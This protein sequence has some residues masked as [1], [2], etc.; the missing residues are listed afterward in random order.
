MP[1]NDPGNAATA[2]EQC[3]GVHAHRE[4]TTNETLHDRY[5][6]DHHKRDRRRRVTS[7]VACIALTLALMSG[8]IVSL[9]LAS[10]V[11]AVLASVSWLSVL[12][13]NAGIMNY[14]YGVEPRSKT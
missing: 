4:R 14:R 5:K 12:V 8:T 7:L 1:I 2:H 6:Q 3:S 13:L 10:W 9:V 11:P